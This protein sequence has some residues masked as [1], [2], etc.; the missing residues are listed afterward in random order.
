ML[1]I[2]WFISVLLLALSA[3]IAF[4]HIL[5]IPGK[6]ALPAETVVAIQQ[7]L[8]PGYRAAGMVI[9]PLQLIALGAAA[10]VAY[11]DATSF[12]LT[13]GALAATLAAMLVFVSWTDVENRRMA[14]WQLGEPL[15]PDWKRVRVRWELSHGG[16]AVLFL[17]S[18]ALVLGAILAG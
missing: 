3:G 9:E 1:E 13:V 4:T 2:L 16:R 14:R 10:A 11:G 17:A 6:R 7:Q 8:Y 15:P 18:V 12:W 5:E